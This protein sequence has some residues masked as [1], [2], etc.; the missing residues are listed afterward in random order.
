MLLV[1]NLLITSIFFALNWVLWI[2]VVR[3]VRW[4]RGRREAVVAEGGRNP[5]TLL[6]RGSCTTSSYKNK[7]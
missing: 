3:E 7:T 2:Q 6:S 5:L 1:S 4:V